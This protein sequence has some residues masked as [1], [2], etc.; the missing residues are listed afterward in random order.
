[1]PI[2]GDKCPSLSGIEEEGHMHKGNSC[3]VFRQ[4]RETRELFLSLLFLRRSQFKIILMPKW[5]ISG[6]HILTPF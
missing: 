6:L 3:P 4:V 1:M 5:H 2:F